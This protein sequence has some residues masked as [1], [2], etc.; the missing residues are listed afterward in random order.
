MIPVAASTALYIRKLGVR[1]EVQNTRDAAAYYN[2]LATERGVD[3]VAAALIPVGYTES[4][5]G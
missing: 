3:D 2:M 4:V 1:M 5:S